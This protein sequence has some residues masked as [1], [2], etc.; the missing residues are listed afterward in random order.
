MSKY[1]CPYCDAP[2]RIEPEGDE[3]NENSFHETQCS[4][5]EKYFVFTTFITVSHELSKAD[6]LNGSDHNYRLSGTFSYIDYCKDCGHE[7]RDEVKYLNFKNEIFR[8]RQSDQP[9]TMKA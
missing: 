4:S 2:A 6:C 7:R 5:C 3:F 1:Q 8:S 9:Q